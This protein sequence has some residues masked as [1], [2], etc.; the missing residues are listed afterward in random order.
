MA[1][2]KSTIFSKDQSGQPNVE[3]ESNGLYSFV[4]NELPTE[5]A[6]NK[7]ALVFKNSLRLKFLIGIHKIKDYAVFFFSSSIIFE[8]SSTCLI[9]S[10]SE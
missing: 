1:A 8:T 6:L 5:A 7:M 10:A 4:V 2:A 3:N 9:S